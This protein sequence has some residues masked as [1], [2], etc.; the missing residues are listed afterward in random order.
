M[1]F[2]NS[3]TQGNKFDE[4]AVAPRSYSSLLAEY[5]KP[6]ARP[7]PSKRREVVGKGT[8]DCLRKCRF[9][10]ANWTWVLNRS[11]LKSALTFHCSKVIPRF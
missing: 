4:L 11:K 7:T 2:L 3:K 9:S 6:E 10:D 5:F 1:E 8:T